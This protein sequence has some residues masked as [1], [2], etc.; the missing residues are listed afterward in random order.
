MCT[1]ECLRNSI[2]TLRNI[3]WEHAI[4]Y[5]YDPILGRTHEKYLDILNSIIESNHILR[6][7][8]FTI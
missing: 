3:A 2:K 6:K 7:E 1:E 4:K 5:E 8:E